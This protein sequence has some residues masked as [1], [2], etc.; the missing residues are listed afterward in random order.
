MFVKAPRI[1]LLVPGLLGLPNLVQWDCFPSDIHG[2]GW[3]GHRAA[4]AV[5]AIPMPTHVQD[6]LVTRLEVSLSEHPSFLARPLQVVRRIEA[7]CAH[8]CY[9]KCPLG[10][11]AVPLHSTAIVADDGDP[12]RV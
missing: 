8:C 1:S 11:L 2:Q 4:D 6:V 9:V 5:I 7:N 12:K 10:Q 3:D